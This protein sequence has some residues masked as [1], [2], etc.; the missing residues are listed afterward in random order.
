MISFFFVECK[1]YNKLVKITRVDSQIYSTN[2]W[3][4]VG[5]G[6]GE[7]QYWGRKLRACV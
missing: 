1:N 7:G 4:P 2:Y 3:L 5:R 6:S